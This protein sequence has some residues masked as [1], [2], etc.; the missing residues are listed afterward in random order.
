MVLDVNPKELEYIAKKIKCVTTELLPE[1]FQWINVPMSV[2]ADL[3]DVDG[4]WAT[5]KHYEF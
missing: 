4:S 1:T 3:G 2:D 5:M